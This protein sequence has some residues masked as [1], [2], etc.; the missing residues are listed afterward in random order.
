M[1]QRRHRAG[2]VRREECRQCR[3]PCRG[4]RLEV[5]CAPRASRSSRFDR[6]RANPRS[7]RRRL[8]ARQVRAHRLQKALR[9]AQ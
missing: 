6:A 3:K 5:F 9:E 4:R 2:A 7:A 1:L 8:H